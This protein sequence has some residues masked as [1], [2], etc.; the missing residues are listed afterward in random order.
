MPLA[1]MTQ[2]TEGISTPTTCWHRLGPKRLTG[3]SACVVD[4]G[5]VGNGQ[6]SYP[7]NDGPR[8]IKERR[9]FVIAA[10]FHHK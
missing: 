9:C 3:I 4:E 1:E 6:A 7:F 5:V 10:I 8:F 2:P